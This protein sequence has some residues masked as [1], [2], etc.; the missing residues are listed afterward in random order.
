MN[1]QIQSSLQSRVMHSVSA[2]LITLTTLTPVWADPGGGG[3]GLGG[4]GASGPE[5]S[6]WYFMLIGAVILGGVSLY[7]ARARAKRDM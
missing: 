5:P 1:K 2:A 4:G 3:G 7:R 6:Q